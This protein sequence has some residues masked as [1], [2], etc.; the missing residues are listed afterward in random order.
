MMYKYVL[1]KTSWG[2]VI[3]I[4][5]E[6]IINP[7]ILDT[8]IEVSERIYLRVC[9]EVRLEKEIVEKFISN[10][11]R[12]L[13][14]EIYEIL[15]GSTVCSHVKSLEFSN[16]DFQVEGLYCAIREWTSKYYGFEI[17]PVNVVYDKKENK[18]IFEIPFFA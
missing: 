17:E 11:I 10:G 18:Y 13:K 6:E 2:I 9:N 14:K 4:D 5:V 12:S 7:A 15:Q 3:F 8:D 16:V 1:L